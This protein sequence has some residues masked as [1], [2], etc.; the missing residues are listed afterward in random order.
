MIRDALTEIFTKALISLGIN[1][2]A[3]EFEYPREKKFGDYATNI[4]MVLAKQLKKNPKDIATELISYAKQV[5]EENGLRIIKDIS[6]VPP[7]FINITL[8]DSI[9]AWEVSSVLEHKERY[10]SSNV[11]QSKTVVIDYFQPNIAKPLHVGHLR[12]AVIGDSLKRVMK[13]LG[14]RVVADSHVGDWGFQ[15]GLIVWAY[16][17][18]GDRKK[19]ESNPL[20][21]LLALYVKANKAMEEDEHVRDLAKQEFKKI[22]EGDQENTNLWEWFVD[23]SM[24]E[25]IEMRKQFDILPFEV[26]LGESFYQNRIF[27]DLKMLQ[28]KGVVVTGEDGEQYIDLEDLGL[29]RLILV[30]AAGVTM[31]A[32]RDVSTLLHRWEQ[33]KYDHNIYVVDHRQGFYFKQFFAAMKKAGLEGVEQS[34]HVS[35]GSMASEDG[36]F[37]TREGKHIKLSSVL[38][39]LKKNAVAII[40][41]KN[42]N[43]PKKEEVAHGVAL[44]ALKYGD[45]SHDRQTDIT[46]RW[47]DILSFEGKTG[48]YIQYSNAR[49]RSILRKAEYDPFI[50]HDTALFGDVSPELRD[51]ASLVSRFPYTVSQT[52]LLYRPNIL[53]EYLY[54][55]ASAVNTFYAEHR[56]L[57]E[58]DDAKKKMRLTVIAA[59]A[60]VLENGLRLLGISVPDEM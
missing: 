27:R 31:Y 1:D 41:E 55:L 28:E 48:P 26:D 56:V 42:P 59:A 8:S 49:L 15:F 21:E 11:G 5:D 60:Q 54:D 16:H 9:L 4:A 6:F 23:V 40:E 51:I 12:S 22:E 35:F 24:K 20:D 36:A 32:L 37:S 25:L 53:A 44:A 57:N 19:I 30:N 34:V 52:A 47:S 33:W 17:Q 58:P 10:G 14:Y 43:L 38:S 46:F 3:V 45:L 50:S 18:W 39:E 29:G 13:F 2:Q 7:G